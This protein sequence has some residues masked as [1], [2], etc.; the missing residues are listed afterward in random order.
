MT[1]ELI[2]L[3]VLE[4]KVYNKPKLPPLRS[5]IQISNPLFLRRIKKKEKKT[6]PAL[7]KKLV[8]LLLKIVWS[9]PKNAL[10]AILP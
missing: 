10:I 8:K 7:G 4:F 1:N 6:V 5:F 2:Q 9:I 3:N